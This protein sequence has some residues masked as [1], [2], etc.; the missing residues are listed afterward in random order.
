MYSVCKVDDVPSLLGVLYLLF[1][2]QLFTVVIS[3]HCASDLFLLGTWISPFIYFSSDIRTISLYFTKDVVMLL[4]QEQKEENLLYYKHSGQV[5]SVNMIWLCSAFPSAFSKKRLVFVKWQCHLYT[6]YIVD[7]GAY[8]N[9]VTG[10]CSQLQTISAHRMVVD[11]Y[12]LAI[13]P[14]NHPCKLWASGYVYPLWQSFLDTGF[15]LLDLSKATA[16]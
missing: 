10:M 1:F 15:L 3:T 12:D 7:V 4:E 2:V 8:S 5:T 9:N 14:I 13:L 6:E 11:D 16:F